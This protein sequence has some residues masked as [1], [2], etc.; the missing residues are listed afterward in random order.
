MSTQNIIT[1]Q[2]RYLKVQWNG[3]NTLSYPKFDIAKM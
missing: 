1:G 2:P 3:G